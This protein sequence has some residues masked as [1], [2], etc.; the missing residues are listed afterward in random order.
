[1]CSRLLPWAKGV[2]THRSADRERYA[3]WFLTLDYQTGP[4]FLEHVGSIRTL[5]GRQTARSDPCRNPE[6]IRK[7]Q[8]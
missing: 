4:V 7:V 1:M 8:G 2:P 6:A 5:K 3:A